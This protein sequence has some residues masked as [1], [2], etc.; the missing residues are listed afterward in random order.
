MSM[1]TSPATDTATAN[2]RPPSRLWTGLSIAGALTAGVGSIVGLARIDRIY[3]AETESF[4]AQAIAQDLVNLVVVA[5]LLLVMSVLVI[6]GS[7]RAYLVWLG[8]LS[9]TVYSYVIYTVSISFGPLFLVWLAALA[10]TLYALIGG[11]IDVDANAIA[12][13]FTRP[14]QRFAAIFLIVTAMLF[15]FLWLSDIVPA[16]LD[17]TMPKSAAELD[18]PTSP[19][20]VLDLGFFLPAVLIV[21]IQLLRKRPLGYMAGPGLLVFLILT[22]L[23]ILITPFISVARDQEPAWGVMGPIGV[24]TV[25]ALAALTRMLAAAARQPVR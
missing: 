22:G 25:I 21:G 17:G 10:F 1:Q 7:L 14:A 5:P 9:F 23:P 4:I 16:L 24:I 15:V 13:R 19:V 18:L 2:F 8:A 12:R 6:R 11:L 3:G 20:H